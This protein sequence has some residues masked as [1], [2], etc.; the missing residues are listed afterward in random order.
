MAKHGSRERGNQALVRKSVTKEEPLALL[1]VPGDAREAFHELCIRTGRQVR[2][3]MMEAD[4]EVLCG[5]KGR[6]REGRRAWRGG[7]TPIRVTLGDRRVELPRLRVRSPEGE[8]AL[9][10]FE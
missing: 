6:H 3:A 10:G 7:S 5:A 4:R 1:G 2:L 9:A 8:V